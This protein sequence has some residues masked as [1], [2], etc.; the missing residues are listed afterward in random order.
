MLRSWYEE[1]NSLEIWQKLRLI[2]AHSTEVYIPLNFHQ[3]PFNVGLPIRLPK[4]T[5]IQVEALAKKYNL[6]ALTSTEIDSLTILVGGHP[7]LIKLAL[8]YLYRDQID[9]PQL[10]KLAP[11]QSGIYGAILRHHW[12]TIQQYP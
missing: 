11:T 10:V 3:S 4:L 5:V 7:Y 1:A 12:Q 2:V 6:Q 8:Y 9:F